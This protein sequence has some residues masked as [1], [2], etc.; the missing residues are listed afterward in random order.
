MGSMCVRDSQLGSMRIDLVRGQERCSTT[1]TDAAEIDFM[2][3]KQL[4]VDTGTRL[5]ELTCAVVGGY[6]G[7]HIKQPFCTRYL[8]DS[9]QRLTQPHDVLSLR[10]YLPLQTLVTP[11]LR[12]LRRHIADKLIGVTGGSTVN[13]QISRQSVFMVQ[14][15]LS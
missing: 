1:E 5:R 7:G 10:L 12:R 4:G 13:K 2:N 11:G 9:K 8:K 6:R 15:D 14:C 3:I